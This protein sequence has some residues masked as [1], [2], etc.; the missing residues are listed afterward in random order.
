MNIF[1]HRVCR[2]NDNDS[3]SILILLNSCLLFIKFKTCVH[4]SHNSS[5]VLS[6]RG[7][8]SINV[9]EIQ[10]SHSGGN[11]VVVFWV[12]ILTVCNMAT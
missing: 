8:V 9:Y 6:G 2:Q 12:V 10:G 7:S 3:S 1:H 4:V 11:C 5:L